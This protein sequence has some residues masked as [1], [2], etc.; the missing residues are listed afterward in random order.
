M[1]MHR[2]LVLTIAL[3][4]GAVSARPAPPPDPDPWKAQTG[5]IWSLIGHYTKQGGG[6]RLRVPM[7][8]LTSRI[9]CEHATVR[10]CEKDLKWLESPQIWTLLDGVGADVGNYGYWVSCEPY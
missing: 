8:L 7:C 1:N 5:Q 6:P 3:A 10:S 4:A 2:A 9:A